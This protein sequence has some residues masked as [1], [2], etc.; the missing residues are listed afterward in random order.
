MRKN[1]RHF[2]IVLGLVEGEYYVMRFGVKQNG[3]RVFQ[4]LK[5]LLKDLYANC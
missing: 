4:V 5:V 2:E 3:E 1:K